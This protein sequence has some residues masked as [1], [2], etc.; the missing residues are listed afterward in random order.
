MF[1]QFDD[2]DIQMPAY[3]ELKHHE[4]H[5]RLAG[6][7]ITCPVACGQTVAPCGTTG[8]TC[9]PTGTSGIQ[10]NYTLN[11]GCPS[12]YTVCPN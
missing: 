4:E 11:N 5:T 9:N 1:Q 2:L 12:V 8:G 6:S 10:C 7:L 3:G